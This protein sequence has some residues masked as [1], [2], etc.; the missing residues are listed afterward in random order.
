[1]STSVLRH[2]SHCKLPH[3]TPQMGPRNVQSALAL[4]YLWLPSSFIAFTLKPDS[5]CVEAGQHNRDAFCFWSTA[6]NIAHKSATSGARLTYPE[7]IKMP[8]HGKPS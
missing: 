3:F 4:G 1:M 5:R 6:L 7:R 8:N 2:P